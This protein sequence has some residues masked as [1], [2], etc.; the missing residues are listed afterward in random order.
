MR[1]KMFLSFKSKKDKFGRLSKNNFFFISVF[2]VSGFSV[3]FYFYTLYNLYCIIYNLYSMW[4]TR[5]SSIKKYN[6][7]FEKVKK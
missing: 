6:E 5:S 3:F 2:S 7:N 1:N 4:F